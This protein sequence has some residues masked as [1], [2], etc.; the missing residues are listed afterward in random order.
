MK[1]LGRF[2][3][4]TLALALL[5]SLIFTVCAVM[6]VARA[7]DTISDKVIRLHILADSDSDTDQAEK[8][9]IRDRILAESADCTFADR[10]DAEAQLAARLP[11][12]ERIATEQLRADGFSDSVHA[13]L[14]DMHFDARTYGDRTLPAGTYRAV[15]ITIGSGR[16]HNWWCVVYPPICLSPA[17][18]SSALD[19]VL[20]DS[21][22]AIVR[23]PTHYEIRLKLVEWGRML[24]DW[25]FT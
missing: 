20:T 6:P 24:R 23:E 22:R 7:C 17:V 5:G 14:T 18:D 19:D 2:I 16:G 25:L 1:N 9:R 3:R 11:E 4:C 10:A 21:E 15:R 8:L 13:E 12:L